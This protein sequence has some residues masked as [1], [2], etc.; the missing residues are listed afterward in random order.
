MAVGKSVVFL[1][2]MATNRHFIAGVG[3]RQTGKHAGDPLIRVEVIGAGGPADGVTPVLV[4]VRVIRTG[5][6]M[7]CSLEL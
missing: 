7:T 6:R 2:E 3:Q 4:K 5:L 1:L